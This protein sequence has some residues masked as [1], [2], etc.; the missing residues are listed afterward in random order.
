MEKYRPPPVKHI[1][2]PPKRRCH[3][4]N[5]AGREPCPICRGAGQVVLGKDVHARALYGACTGCFGNRVK[6]CAVCGG[7]GFIV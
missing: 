3:R 4:C 1:P 2:P 6:R 7:E 5:G